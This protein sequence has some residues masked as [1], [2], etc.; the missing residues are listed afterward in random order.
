MSTG[1]DQHTNLP[2]GSLRLAPNV[3]DLEEH[4]RKLPRQF[5]NFVFN[6]NHLTATIHRICTYLYNVNVNVSQTNHVTWP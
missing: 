5:V 2:R 6:A 4:K 3:S 1:R